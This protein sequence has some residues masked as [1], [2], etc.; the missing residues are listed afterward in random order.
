VASHWKLPYILSHPL[1]IEWAGWH[2]DTHT[3]QQNGWQLSAHQDIVGDELRLALKHPTLHVEG[4][5]RKIPFHYRRGDNFLEL[6]KY[7]GLVADL[8]SRHMIHISSLYAL[9]FD[10]FRPINAT[11]QY[12]EQC[13]ATNSLSDYIH[14]AHINNTKEIIIPE[15]NVQELLDKILEI[16]TPSRNEYFKKIIDG[17]EYIPSRKIHA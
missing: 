8:A 16:Q 7:E 2:S 11:P 12:T 14:F 1:K 13:I 3:L 6:L 5:T 4:L 10:E 15:M 9:R 17:E